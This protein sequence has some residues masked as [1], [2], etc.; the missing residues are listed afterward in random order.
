[1]SSLKEVQKK[2]ILLGDG[3]V[4]KTSLIRRFVVDKFDDKYILTVGS[5]ITAKEIQINMK[6]QVFIVK[7][8]IWDI[9]GQRGFTKLHQSSFRGTHGV[10]L[11]ADITRMD[12]LRSLRTYW[13][14]E[15]QKI[16]GS[17]PFVILVNKYDLMDNAKFNEEELTEF[18]SKYKVPFYFTSAKNG[19]NVKKAFYTLGKSMIELKGIPQPKPQET[20]IVADSNIGMVEVIDWIIDDFCMEYG[21]HEDAMPVVRK[22]FKLAKL[23]LK[24]PSKD[25]LRLVIERLATVE[26]GFKEWEIVEANRI[27]RLK[28]IKDID[29]G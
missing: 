18:A 10:F 22:Q 7:L 2:I 3:A 11:V 27:K 25:A 4:G 29:R 19:D 5:K 17:V 23:D 14:P 24:N 13:V 8:Q 26:K 9:L 16:A 15:V 12:T 20:K 1:M 21:K 28:W 6:E